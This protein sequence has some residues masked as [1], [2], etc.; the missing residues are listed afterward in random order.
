[1]LPKNKG[2]ER[3]ENDLYET[4]KW[5]TEVILP[6]IPGRVQ[7]IW[8]PACGSGQMVEAFRKNGYLV[9]ATDKSTGDDFLAQPPSEHADAI[10]TN[11]PY[12]IAGEFIRHALNVVKPGGFVATLMRFEFDAAMSRADLFAHNPYFALKVVMT[13]RIRWIEGSK[14]RPSIHHAWFIWDK[15]HT[16][17]PSMRWHFKDS[18]TLSAG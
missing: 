8:E 16:G 6:F 15:T 18:K 1:M 10:I 5:A 9:R 11:P 3:I 7:T 14:G 13:N 12:N 4:P 2:Y 17:A